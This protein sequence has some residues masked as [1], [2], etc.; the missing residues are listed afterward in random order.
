MEAVLLTLTFASQLYATP[1]V[2]RDSDRLYVAHMLI[3]CCLM[4]AIRCYARFTGFRHETFF[5]DVAKQIDIM[6]ILKPSEKREDRHPF[7]F[8]FFPAYVAHR[9]A[10][11][12]H[13]TKESHG[14]LGGYE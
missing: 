10:L 9:T 12:M 2:R 3:G 1:H 6:G 11:P 14:P 7:F 13:V 8:S 4:R 5:P